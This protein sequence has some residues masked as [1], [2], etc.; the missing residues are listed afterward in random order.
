M[1]MEKI[2]VNDLTLAFERRGKGTPL[3]LLHGYPLDHHIWDFVV[4]LLE[5][6]FDII[7]PDLRGFGESTLND[8]TPTMDTFA[9]D[10]VGLLDALGIEKTALAGHS[11]GGYIALAFTKLYPERVSGLGM[12]STQT[13]ADPP[14]KKEGRYK[15]AVD[16][17]DHGIAGVVEAMA[18]KFTADAALQLAAHEIMEKQIPSA[19][20]GALKAMAERMNTNTVLASLIF[21]LVLIH[22]DQDQLIPIDRAREVKSVVPAAHLI[23]LQGIG[24]IPMME[25]PSETAS[26]LKLLK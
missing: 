5:D 24:H 10:I 6:T 19:Y 12:I 21:P 15:S 2:Q 1:K 14:D 20:I 17:A 3:V 16:V 18:P 25:A 4:P 7:M 22:G 23:E 13:V 11:M 9:S 26:A 8:T